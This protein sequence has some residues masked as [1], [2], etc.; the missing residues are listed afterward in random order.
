MGG[1][2]GGG[3]F[4]SYL[5]EGLQPKNG[6]T[7]VGEDSGVEAGRIGRGRGSGRGNCGKWESLKGE[8]RKK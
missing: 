1:G 8:K 2:G 4:V 5:W 6:P 3:G 7:P